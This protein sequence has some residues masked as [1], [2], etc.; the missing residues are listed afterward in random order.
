MEP[1]GTQSR[2]KHRYIANMREGG[3]RTGYLTG[4]EVTETVVQFDPMSVVTPSLWRVS[5]CHQHLKTRCIYSDL[6]QAYL[7]EDVSLLYK[8]SRCNSRAPIWTQS[9]YTIQKANFVKTLWFLRNCKP[10]RQVALPK[11]VAWRSNR[12]K[13][14]FKIQFIGVGSE[15]RCVNDRTFISVNHHH[16]IIVLE[17][18]H[19]KQNRSW[20]KGNITPLWRLVY[21]LYNDRVIHLWEYLAMAN[22]NQRDRFWFKLVQNSNSKL[23]TLSV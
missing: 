15:Y 5:A 2:L 20:R 6:P 4:T 10:S 9:T 23:I 11:P 19:I 1:S 22:R 7:A 12:P 3:S 16:C 17:Q 18:Q 21:C 14:T 8:A 13:K